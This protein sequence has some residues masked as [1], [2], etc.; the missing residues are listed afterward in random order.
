MEIGIYL[1][2]ILGPNNN[3]VRN[4]PRKL[5]ILFPT[6]NIINQNVVKQHTGQNNWNQ[7]KLAGESWQSWGRR[8]SFPIRKQFV[9]STVNCGRW[10]QANRV[11]QKQRYQPTNWQCPLLSFHVALLIQVFCCFGWRLND[12]NPWLK[13]AVYV[14]SV[15]NPRQCKDPREVN[16]KWSQIW[17][18]LHPNRMSLLAC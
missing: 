6:I 13:C 9:S 3:C 11:K 14:Q 15:I 18:V 16:P 17:H 2:N 10:E 7:N 5:C 12:N 1:K 4:S 8:E